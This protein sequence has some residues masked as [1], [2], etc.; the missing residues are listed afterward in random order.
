MDGK[1]HPEHH[2]YRIVAQHWRDVVRAQSPHHL[3]QPKS[4]HPAACLA[5]D[6]GGSARRPNYYLINLEI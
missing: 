1:V 2:H 6:T 4:H 5:G 3:G